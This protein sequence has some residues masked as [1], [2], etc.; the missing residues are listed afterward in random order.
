MLLV[1]CSGTKLNHVCSDR[2]DFYEWCKERDLVIVNNYIGYVL[3]DINVRDVTNGFNNELQKLTSKFYR[4]TQVS[5][6]LI[7]ITNEDI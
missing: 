6:K 3:P 7:G 4:H 2:E 1:G 5:A